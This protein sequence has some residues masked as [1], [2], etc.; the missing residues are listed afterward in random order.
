[1]GTTVSTIVTATATMG[2]VG[3]FFAIAL[4]ALAKR[5]A[6]AEDEQ[7]ELLTNLLPGNNCGACGMAGCA[8]LAQALAKGEAVPQSCPVASESQ[9]QK[10]AEALGL[11]ETVHRERRVARV[12]CGGHRAIS[13]WRADYEG[14]LDCR[15]ADLVGK[16]GKGC[17]FGCLGLGTCSRVCPYGA[18]T[19]SPTGLPVVNE[20]LCTGCGLCEAACPR[21]V[22]AVMDASQEVFVRCVSTAPGKQVRSVCEVGCIGCGICVRVCPENA[23]E[24]LGHLACVDPNR[25]TACGICV[26]KCP[27][28]AMQIILE[29]AGVLTAV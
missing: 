27:T 2:A 29:D 7:I 8:A 20:A 9:I 22:I 14:V 23:V 17:V 24:M 5:T 28:D 26:E 12:R 16:G 21:G 3:A 19:M 6:S 1:M 10:L 25:C 13:Q 15:A 4:V 11:T 18:I